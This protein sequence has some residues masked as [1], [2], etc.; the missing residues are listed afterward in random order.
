M[1][2]RGL[3]ISSKT[4]RQLSLTGGIEDYLSL[5]D[6]ATIIVPMTVMAV[7][8]MAMNADTDSNAAEIHADADTGVGHA[9]AKQGN[10]KN[11]SNK[12]FHLIASG[13]APLSCDVRHCAGL[14]QR[15]LAMLK[16]S[17]TCPSTDELQCYNARVP[18]SPNSSANIQAILIL[19]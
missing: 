2:S 7:V 3:V 14:G 16:G 4:A 18:I 12:G 1:I 13:R 10:C 8:M 19:P 5:G 6:L 9:N 17:F 11:R 15:R